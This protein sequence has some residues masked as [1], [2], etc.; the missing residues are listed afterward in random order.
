MR[1]SAV[2][3]VF[4][5]TSVLITF[6]GS[7]ASQTKPNVP[8]FT[9]KNVNYAIEFTIKNEPFTPF[10]VQEGSSNWT[11]NYYYSVRFKNT[12]EHDWHEIFLVSD[13][14]PRQDYGSNYTV[15]SFKG[16]CSLNDG[17]KL[18][19]GSIMATFASGSQVDFQL[20]AMIGYIT[21]EYAGN[22]GPSSYPYVFK[23]E[24]SG[25]SPTQTIN[26]D[27]S[28]FTSTA[29]PN[30]T[31]LPS[32]NFPSS[33]SGTGVDVF[34]LGWLGVALVVFVVVLAVLLVAV[35]VFWRRR[36]S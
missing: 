25:W 36:K 9:V 6:G 1:K 24:V 16:E 20:Q 29:T 5:I 8:D 22:Y 12:S 11:S 3:L 2:L 21:R 33:S 7:F 10:L 4:L 18:N 35:A 26:I 31:V 13:G 28:E 19:E 34:G 23:G 30:A 14:Y 15:I 17:F 32:Q 27:S